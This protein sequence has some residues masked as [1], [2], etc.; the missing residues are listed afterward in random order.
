MIANKQG[1]QTWSVL[2]LRSGELRHTFK[3]SKMTHWHFHK[4]SCLFSPTVI[5]DI[6]GSL[7]STQTWKI[8]VLMTAISQKRSTSTTIETDLVFRTVLRN[9]HLVRRAFL[10]SPHLQVRLTSARRSSYVYDTVIIQW[11]SRLTTTRQPNREL[12]GSR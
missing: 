2:F 7:K 3:M 12:G 1:W 9:H 5:I 4:R 6:L 11:A 10:T 8:P